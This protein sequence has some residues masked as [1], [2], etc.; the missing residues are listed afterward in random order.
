MRREVVVRRHWLDEKAFF[1]G[2]AA[3][4]LIP[5][6]S[7]TELAML[8]GLRR[9]GVPG[10]LTA[11]SLFILPAML[12]MLGLAWLYASFGHTAVLGNALSGVRPVVV[13]IIVWAIVDLARRIVR[14]PY[15]LLVAT[16]IAIAAIVAV[17]PVLLLVIGGLLLIVR[18]VLSLSISAASMFAVPL[19]GKAAE[20]VTHV[21][22]LSIFVT[23][24]KYGAVSFGSGYVLFALLHA[25][26]VQS[27]HWLTTRQLID[28]IAIS[29]A[30]PGPVFTVATFIGFLVG[31]LPGALLATLGIF[32]PGFLLVPFL[33]RIV[34][35]V[36]S[37]P[38][39]RAFLDGVNVA[40]VGLIASV[41]VQ[42][43]RSALVDLPT[44]LVAITAFAVLL[45]APLAAPI[46]VIVGAALGLLIH[47][48]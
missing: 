20:V 34:R 9:G 23:F 25:D 18:R 38:W 43:A 5:G 41:A 47:G 21:S 15:A 39:L 13:G 7:S 29:Q 11:G 17:N 46:L 10:L 22:L 27:L 35:L 12:L 3:C 8:I 6:P 31:G 1:D 44:A 28:A 37:R 36:S 14:E 4:Q 33:D 40:A 24:L 30:T 42:L 19:I 32:L 26:L 16:L 45:R 48:L 2:F